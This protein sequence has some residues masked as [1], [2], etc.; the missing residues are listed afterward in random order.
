MMTHASSSFW[1]GG[2]VRVAI[3]QEDEEDDDKHVIVFLV[4]RSC[5][6]NNKVRRLGRR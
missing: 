1:L 2:V 5:E 3:K 4:E 6:G